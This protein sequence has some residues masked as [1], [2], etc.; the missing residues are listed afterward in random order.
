MLLKRSSP[1]SL[2]EARLASVFGGM[3]FH[4]WMKGGFLRLMPYWVDAR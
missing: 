1:E 2:L 4:A 3:P